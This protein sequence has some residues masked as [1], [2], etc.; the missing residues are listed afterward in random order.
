MS[1]NVRGGHRPRPTTNR[2]R[3]GLGC[4]FLDFNTS[5]VF[6]AASRRR[7]CLPSTLILGAEN[8]RPRPIILVIR[9][10][11]RAMKARKAVL[12]AQ[13]ARYKIP[14]WYT[15]RPAH[16]ISSDTWYW[17]YQL[18]QSLKEIKIIFPETINNII[19][20]QRLLWKLFFLLFLN[21]I[22]LISHQ[23]RIII[24][25]TFWAESQNHSQD[26]FKLT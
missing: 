11:H 19:H 21:L 7:H 5:L 23:N 6:C 22:F 2:R 26:I 3:G 17:S 20:Y 13:F 18:S 25:Y 24:V 4:L 1:V 14:S 16:D 9:C 10:R 15:R 12:L 8:L